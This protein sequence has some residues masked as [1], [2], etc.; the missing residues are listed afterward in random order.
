L[1]K[2][3]ELFSFIFEY[4]KT[5]KY[6]LY[7][8]VMTQDYHKKI[9]HKWD[10]KF[11]SSLIRLANFSN[12]S[13]LFFD[14]LNISGIEN[15]RMIEDKQKVYVSNHVSLADFLVQGY[16][17][18]NENLPMPRII[19]GENLFHFPFGFIWKRCGA[20]AIDR[21]KKNK[22]YLKSY[23][24]TIDE[25]I[26]DGDDLL[27]YPEGGRS[28][29]GEILN[30][31]K[32]G[33]LKHILN[34]KKEILAVPVFVNY[35]KRI[36]EGSL[37]LLHFYKSRRDIYLNKQTEFCLKHKNFRAFYNSFLTKIYDGLYF[38]TDVIAYFNRIF[39]Y[40]KGNAYLSFGKGFS[41]G[42]FLNTPL[43]N[44]DLFQE[45]IVNSWK[46]LQNKI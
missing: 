27:I 20:V 36:E 30:Q 31:L 41:I 23:L 42:N 6:S 39:D 33:T 25:I 43:N 19:A 37:D 11:Y 46:D 16:V 18:G 38:G 8:E 34:N 10:P 14:N 13:N 40:K 29:S 44:S 15:I 17:F 9:M 3:F 5:F 22:T 35:D 12:F 45:K 28:Y 1:K 32:M 24:Q 4:I 7:E 26:S 2:K 21:N